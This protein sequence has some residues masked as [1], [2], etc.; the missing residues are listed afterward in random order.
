[1]SWL[2]CEKTSIETVE[3]RADIKWW[4]EIFCFSDE[5]DKRPHIFSNETYSGF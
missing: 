5:E 4:K 1:M 2:C 3:K